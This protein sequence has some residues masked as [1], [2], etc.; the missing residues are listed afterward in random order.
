MIESV[1][2]TDGSA[3]KG[4]SHAVSGLVA[5]SRVRRPVCRVLRDASAAAVIVG[6]VVA[7]TGSARAGFAHASGLATPSNGHG[8]L[9]LTLP[10]E[11]RLTSEPGVVAQQ[12]TLFVRWRIGPA[13]FPRQGATLIMQEVPLRSSAS[14]RAECSTELKN[15]IA[16]LYA[17]PPTSGFHMPTGSRQI[18]ESESAVGTYAYCAEIVGAAFPFAVLAGPTWASIRVLGPWQPRGTACRSITR[19]EVEQSLEETVPSGRPMGASEC[20]FGTETLTLF[21]IDVVGYDTHLEAIDNLEAYAK[22]CSRATLSRPLVAATAAF[23]P[24]GYGKLDTYLFLVAAGR[25]SLQ[26]TA[27]VPS[28]LAVSHVRDG[29]ERLAAEAIAKLGE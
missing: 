20:A 29:L 12:E 18:Q 3:V 21:N 24:Y 8:V 5:G 27:T 2:L 28:S 13:T 1:L 17:G 23:C 19:G 6:A 25:V 4:A 9:S 16:S 15:E 7:V 10:S 22:H 11:T 26:L 14:P